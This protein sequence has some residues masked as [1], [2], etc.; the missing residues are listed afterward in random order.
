MDIKY[1]LIIF[2]LIIFF[3]FGLIL[4][5]IIDFIFPDHCEDIPE[6]RIAI[7]I[8]GEIAIVYLILYFLKP[9]IDV[10]LNLFFKLVSRKVPTYMNQILVLAF[11]IGIYKHLNKSTEKFNYMKDKYFTIF[12]F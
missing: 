7:E 3:L 1:I 9:Y 6:Y 4:S 2:I 8:I 12:S 10:I 5:E 11:S